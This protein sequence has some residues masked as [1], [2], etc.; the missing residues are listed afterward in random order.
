MMVSNTKQPIIPCDCHEHMFMVQVTKV[1]G[2]QD[3]LSK[4]H[5]LRS[6]MHFIL[7]GHAISI[8]R[9]ILKHLTLPPRSLGT[10]SSSDS[11]DDVDPTSILGPRRVMYPVSDPL[12][13]TAVL[14][15]PSSVACLLQ[16]TQWNL[17]PLGKRKT[18]TSRSC[19]L[20]IRNEVAYGERLF[21][22]QLLL[23]CSSFMQLVHAARSC[24]SSVKTH[25]RNLHPVS[26]NE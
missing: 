3:K 13:R 23:T 2:E 20:W 7:H 6:R 24:R 11:N 8:L 9:K 17:R 15:M 10:S 18:W 16:S 12:L 21:R 22:E 14:L 1:K 19:C 25:L 26:L 5:L 4:N